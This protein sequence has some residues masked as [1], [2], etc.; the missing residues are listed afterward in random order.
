M[1]MAKL[2]TTVTINENA[3]ADVLRVLRSRDA[4]SYAAVR[5]DILTYLMAGRI[6]SP[7][8][9]DELAEIATDTRA[10]KA[11]IYAMGIILKS[12]ETGH[13]LREET[14]ENLLAH[15]R[16]Y[17]H[18]HMEELMTRVKIAVYASLE[19]HEL[20]ANLM[21]INLYAREG[22]RHGLERLIRRGAKLETMEIYQIITAV[23]SNDID[24]SRSAVQILRILA[25]NHELDKSHTDLLTRI[26]QLSKNAV[27]SDAV[28]AVLAMQNRNGDEL[29]V[30]FPTIRAP[31]PPESRRIARAN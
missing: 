1:L 13:K 21:H 23:S 24:I 20:I 29:P 10:G 12:I 8:H 25:V 5:T 17:V 4:H 18:T 27:I 16:E 9:L 11:M 19:K 28:H 14:R 15:A 3:P 6:L 30:R 2:D 26:G 22:A 31:R 7:A